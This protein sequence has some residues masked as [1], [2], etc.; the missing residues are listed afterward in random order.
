MHD[1]AAHKQLVWFLH[2]TVKHNITLWC[3]LQNWP[4]TCKC[5][6]QNNFKNYFDR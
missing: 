3:S 5:K 6:N 4:C 2:S 1:F